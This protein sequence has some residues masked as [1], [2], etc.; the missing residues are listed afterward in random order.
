MPQIVHIHADDCEP[1]NAKRLEPQAISSRKM[2]LSARESFQERLQRCFMPRVE[3]F[4]EPDR[5]RGLL[6]LSANAQNNPVDLQPLAGV[7]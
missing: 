4:C 1:C 7:L 2:G 6:T 3:V 5:R